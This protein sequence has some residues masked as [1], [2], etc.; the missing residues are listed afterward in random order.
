LPIEAHIRASAYASGCE[1]FG[2]R[3]AI[4][5]RVDFVA[6]RG[7]GYFM[8]I[9]DLGAIG[10]FLGSL[11]IVVTLVYLAIQNRQQQKLLMSSAFQART[12]T[13]LGLYSEIARD[14]EFAAIVMKSNAGVALTELESF[15]LSYWMQCFLKTGENIFFQAKLGV[16]EEEF[17]A[18][19]E[20]LRDRVVENESMR[21][22]WLA[23]K[24]Q[25]S[26]SFQRY[27]EE[28]L[29]ER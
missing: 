5:A 10:E 29:I 27:I 26:A 2:T 7:I 12:A 9:Q 24:P 8:S 11:V 18:T 1:R 6:R 17:T 23:V 4:I 14:A 22:T 28:R 25:Y 16:I 15:R 19:L 20:A 21:T 3:L 13:L